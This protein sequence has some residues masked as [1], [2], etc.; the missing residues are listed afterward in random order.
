MPHHDVSGLKNITTN[1]ILQLGIPANLKGYHY[2]REAVVMSVCEPEMI[3][4][5][6]GKI[7]AAIAQNHGVTPACVER[8]IATA[9]KTSY[10]RGCKETFA[11]I[12]GEETA[13]EIKR[14]KKTIANKEYIVGL[15]GA[16][17]KEYEME[18]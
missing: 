2:I 10:K 5:I 17:R 16:V 14:G 18:Q 7:Y 15:T 1:L 13:S 8:A 11:D 3:D 12:F 9:I 6:S 4:N